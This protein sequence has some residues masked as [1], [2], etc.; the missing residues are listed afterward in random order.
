MK[1]L[2][3]ITIA[4]NGGFQG[5][6]T[7]PLSKVTDSGVS[8]LSSVLS[9]AIGVM[10]IVGIIWFLFVFVTGAISIIGAG[11]DKQALET[12]KK[13]ITTGIVGLVILIAATF[14]VDLIGA[15]FGI[16][17]LNLVDLFATIIK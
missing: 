2:A 13:K 17:L 4:P 11:G 5:L 8:T 10:T 9:M 15:I 7:G 14:I 1:K 3:D 16:E 12:A 6:G